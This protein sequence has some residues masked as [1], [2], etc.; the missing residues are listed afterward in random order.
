MK[1]KPLYQRDFANLKSFEEILDRF[2]NQ[3]EL[4][5]KP[6]V[7][8][9]RRYF[10]TFDW[11]LYR[12]ENVIEVD[13]LTRDPHHPAAAPEALLNRM[14]SAALG[15]HDV[16]PTAHA[17][18]RGV[19]DMAD[20]RRDVLA[21]NIGEA[22]SLGACVCRLRLL[23]NRSWQR[24][25]NLDQDPDFVW[26]FQDQDL[27][28]YLEPIIAVRRLLLQA[29][30]LVSIE[31]IDVA[32]D[33][34]KLVLRLE[35]EKYLRPDRNGRYRSVLVNCRLNPLRGYSKVCKSMLELID[36]ARGRPVDIDD[37]YLRMLSLENITPAEYSNK[38]NTVFDPEISIGQALAQTLLFH[39]GVIRKNLPGIQ[40]DM[41]TEY[42]HDFRIANRR[43]R[44]LITQIKHVLPPDQQKY[45]KAIFSWLSNETCAHRDLDVF[46]HD[47]PH[48]MRMLPRD[49]RKDL[50]P[51]RKEIGGSGP[52]RSP[53]NVVGTSTWST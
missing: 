13:S 2:R 34:G 30:V 28:Q 52:S 42:L 22:S 39:M 33:S 40:A 46:I 10:D 21:M 23:G 53:W 29:E 32:D 20:R 25:T 24:S 48:F 27:R 5:P 1:K 26:H 4:R 19:C 36:S 31:P 14:G 18:F 47:I 43:S 11:R 3:Y 49:M 38:L 8:L 17:P 12:S 41:D 15:T 7:I 50:E 9:Q 44:T 35:L 37:P 51:L 6:R 16:A 45:Y